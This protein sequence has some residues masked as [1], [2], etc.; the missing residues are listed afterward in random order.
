MVKPAEGRTRWWFGEQHRGRQW[1][2]KRGIEEKEEETP[3]GDG[4]KKEGR[5]RVAGQK[6]RRREWSRGLD[7]YLHSIPT[8]RVD[9]RIGG[10]PAL[11]PF[12]SSSSPLPTLLFFPRRKREKGRVLLDRQSFRLPYSFSPFYFGA[13]FNRIGGG[14]GL[15]NED[16]PRTHFAKFPKFAT[17]RSRAN[18]LISPRI[19]SILSRNSSL[20][21]DGTSPPC[22]PHS[23]SSFDFLFL[24]ASIIFSLSGTVLHTLWSDGVQSPMAF[25]ILP[26]LSASFH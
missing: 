14:G 9:L 2:P 25:S 12:P 7:S 24:H 17:S 5:G 26:L 15:R 23:P 1:M 6:V 11:P 4:K 16:I 19:I 8:G 18:S 13:L 10:R 21:R 22:S 3:V 20:E